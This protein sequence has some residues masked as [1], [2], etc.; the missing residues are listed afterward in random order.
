MLHKD[1]H[2]LF[3]EYF[4]KAEKSRFADPRPPS[5][6]LTAVEGGL[7]TADLWRLSRSIQISASAGLVSERVAN[8]LDI[9]SK[10]VSGHRYAGFDH[11]EAWIE[12]ICWAKKQPNFLKEPSWTERVVHVG[13]AT[14][15]LIKRGY[16]I[17]TW[18]FGPYASSETVKK[19]CD[20]IISL[21]KLLGGASCAQQIFRILVET[22]AVHDGF[23]SSAL[24]SHQCRESMRRPSMGLAPDTRHR[25]PRLSRQRKQAR[26]CLE[27][28]N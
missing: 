15:R 9:V 4:L 5:E 16:R 12:A 8:T 20:Q 6:L 24:E 28:A 18:A 27:D 3:E 25:E 13:K 26:D 11:P 22:K 19:I 7:N 21:V 23:S 17:Q 1:D 2:K 14:S 10:D